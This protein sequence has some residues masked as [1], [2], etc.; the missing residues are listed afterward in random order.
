M[1]QTYICLDCGHTFTYNNK[2]SDGK[3]C[4][5]CDGNIVPC[6]IGID[7]VE[8]KDRSARVSPMNMVHTA[9]MLT[10]MINIGG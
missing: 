10:T 7:L 8:G 9:E 3:C 5:N 2:T 4:P 1:K 6:T